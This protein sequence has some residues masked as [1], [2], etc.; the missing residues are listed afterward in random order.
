MEMSHFAP[1]YDPLHHFLSEDSWP[2]LPPCSIFYDALAPNVDILFQ[3]HPVVLSP[4]PSSVGKSR[5]SLAF[6]D[7]F[8]LRLAS[9]RD[10]RSALLPEEDCA[11][12]FHLWDNTPILVGSFFANGVADFICPLA[13]TGALASFDM[14][15]EIF[16]IPPL[17]I[18]RLHYLVLKRALE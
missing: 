6:R 7:T 17:L 9:Y 13:M 10:I 4:A 1:D 14:L 16:S 5:A 18:N 8:C 3:L 11:A 2:T 15:K 12:A